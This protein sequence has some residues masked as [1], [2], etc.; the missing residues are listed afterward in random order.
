[1]QTYE[2]IQQEIN[3]LKFADPIDLLSLRKTYDD[4]G[5][6]QDESKWSLKM[7]KKTRSLSV[8]PLAG[9]QTISSSE[10][11]VSVEEHE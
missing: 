11:I 3:E 4:Q 6:K 5:T 1:M 9:Q 2:T 10:A 8:Y 7:V